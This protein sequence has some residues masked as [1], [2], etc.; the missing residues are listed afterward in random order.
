MLVIH[1]LRELQESD[2]F[3]QVNCSVCNGT[4]KKQLLRG[5]GVNVDDQI[6]QYCIN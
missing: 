3:S 6:V 4:N 5:G 1:D 2:I